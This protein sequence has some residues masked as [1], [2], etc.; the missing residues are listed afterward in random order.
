[1]AAAIADVADGG[2]EG[3]QQAVVQSRSDGDF[4]VVGGASGLRNR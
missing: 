2:S 3:S 4:A 1:M